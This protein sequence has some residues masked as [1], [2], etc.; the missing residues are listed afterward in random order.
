MKKPGKPKLGDCARCFVPT[1]ATTTE[2]LTTGAGT[3]ELELCDQHDGMYHQDMTTWTRVGRL[4]ETYSFFGPGRRPDEERRRGTVAVAKLA[5]PIPTARPEPVLDNVV[6]DDGEVHLDPFSPLPLPEGYEEWSF[7]KHAIERSGER[8]V[9]P[10]AALWA[11]CQPERI[12]AGN[13]P[14][15]MC[16][17]RDGVR[18]VVNPEQKRIITVIDLTAQTKDQEIT[19]AAS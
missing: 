16:H 10:E 5:I 17:V 1:P 13:L 7:A 19:N 14:G 9:R 11:A 6:D 12:H 2:T 15:V 18:V 4:V 8:A 3:F